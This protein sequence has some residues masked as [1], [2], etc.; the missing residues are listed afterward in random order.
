MEDRSESND[1]EGAARQSVTRSRLI[2]FRDQRTAGSDFVDVVLELARV[3][4]EPV[5][6]FIFVFFEGLLQSME[7]RLGCFEIVVDREQA[8][9]PS[10]SMSS[11]SLLLAQSIP[12]IQGDA[13]VPPNSGLETLRLMIQ[14]PC[15]M[16]EAEVREWAYD[17]N[18]ELIDQDEDVLL[19]DPRY[20]PVLAE[21]AR[22]VT[23]PKAGYIVAIMASF[24]Q[25]RILHHRV[26]EAR[27][28]A[29]VLRL[30]AQ[31]PGG[32]RLAELSF[33]LPA[34]ERLVLPAAMSQAEAD[35][36]AYDLLIRHTARTL[37]TEHEMV[38]GHRVYTYHVPY[39][40]FLYINLATGQWR[41]SPMKRL[42]P[43][44]LSPPATVLASH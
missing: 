14:N 41:Y 25:M 15:D 39:Q 37:V 32:G 9:V 10:T 26:E 8:A 43:A 4:D 22:D 38:V 7:R 35:N 27:A 13:A 6:F 3:L 30:H 18:V 23:C 11:R 44:A 40:P 24:G 42:E 16:S 2:G 20:M 36:L 17:W 29:N 1:G 19:H 31:L 21:C 12:I 33:L 34:F 28:L 5:E